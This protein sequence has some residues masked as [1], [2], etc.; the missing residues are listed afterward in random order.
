M[1]DEV[2]FLKEG[3]EEESV[4]VNE[5]LRHLEG[6][7]ADLRQ[8]ERELITTIKVSHIHFQFLHDTP[9]AEYF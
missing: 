7:N 8:R 3:Q 6:E 9:C 1:S 2:A 4:K 5:K